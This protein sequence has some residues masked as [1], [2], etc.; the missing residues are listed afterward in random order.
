MALGIVV[1][2]P[3]SREPQW[4]RPV[5]AVAAQIAAQRPGI[6]VRCAYL[7]FCVPTLAEA[8]DQLVM[9]GVDVLRI[10]PMF[11]GIGKHARE[12]LPKLATQ[13][14]D[15][16]PQVRIELAPPAGESPLLISVLANLAM[17]DSK[18]DAY[19]SET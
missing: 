2:G 7:E 17:A 10:F 8:A 12:D 18:N 13:L 4:R 11:L 19:T 16:Y 6:F 5:E 9:A 14:R 1:F 3:G 15:H